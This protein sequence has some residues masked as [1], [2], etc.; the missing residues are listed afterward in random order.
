[1]VPEGVRNKVRLVVAVV[2]VEKTCPECGKTH[3]VSYRRRNRQGFCSLEC[4]YKNR[5]RGMVEKNCQHC[6]KPFRGLQK[7]KYCSIACRIAGFVGFTH[8]PA[9]RAKMSAKWTA[10]RRASVRTPTEP[11]ACRYCGTMFRVKRGVNGSKKVICSEACRRKMLATDNH[12]K[13]PELRERM[14]EV[15]RNRS[16]EIRQKIA[17][18]MAKA[19]R[20]GRFEGVRT[21][22][23]DWYKYVAKDGR[24]YKVQGT[25]ELAFIHWLDQ[26]GL[27]FTAHRKWIRYADD[28]GVKRAWYPDFYVEEWGEFVDVKADHFHRP[29]KF[30]RVRESNPT[31]KVR[32]LLAE[33]LKRLGVMIYGA[34]GK[35][36][37][38]LQ[39]LIRSCSQR[40]RI[41]EQRL[42]FE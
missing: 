28:S 2:Q 7:S 13:R 24:S 1:M 26:Q 10:E 15:A 22:R 36:L 11:K 27:Q 18:G 20:D 25:W 12:M 16:P 32:V 3:Q 34:N 37:P 8:S 6:A 35:H 33:D 21:G 38:Y 19:W 29:D 40:P 9:V 31:I 4:A 41:P 23:C 39:S 30:D 17:N 5:P 42:L 14:S